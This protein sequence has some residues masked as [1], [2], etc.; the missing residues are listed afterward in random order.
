MEIAV[1]YRYA[2]IIG[3]LVLALTKGASNRERAFDQ[4]QVTGDT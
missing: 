3:S 2:A 1:R 4:G